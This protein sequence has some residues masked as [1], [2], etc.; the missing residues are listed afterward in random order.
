MPSYVSI[1]TRDYI[2]HFGYRN[3][4]EK[5]KFI[6]G[7]NSSLYGSNVVFGIINGITRRGGNLKGAELSGCAASYRTFR[8]RANYGRDFSWGPALLLSRTVSDS[9]GQVTVEEAENFPGLSSRMS[10]GHRSQIGRALPLKSLLRNAEKFLWSP[11]GLQTPC[12]Q[13]PFRWCNRGSPEMLL[14]RETPCSMMTFL[15]CAP[16]A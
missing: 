1:V 13:R 8:M 6:R 7:P 16:L 3:L 14:A 9:R 5:V 10:N 2:R 15:S 11:N 12:K 4:V